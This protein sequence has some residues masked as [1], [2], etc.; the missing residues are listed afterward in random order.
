MRL[1]DA[2]ALLDKIHNP[3]QQV[4]VARQVNDMP[5]IEP[6][7]KKGKWTKKVLRSTSVYGT[8]IIYQCSEC[9]NL[10]ISK[11][12]YCPNCGSY[13]GGEQNVDE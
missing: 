3:Y 1:I 12:Q 5:T 9:E 11:Y 6:E 7:R 2:D 8:T 4:E 10:S 13:N